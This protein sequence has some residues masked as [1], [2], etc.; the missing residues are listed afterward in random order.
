MIPHVNISFLEPQWST[1][2]QNA[3]K[4]PGPLAALLSWT[5][6]YDTKGGEKT[7][8]LW[9]TPPLPGSWVE[10]QLS[11]Y[12]CRASHVCCKTD[13]NIAARWLW[14]ISLKSEIQVTFKASLLIRFAVLWSHLF[15]K[16][17]QRQIGSSKLLFT[18]FWK[19]YT[20]A[21]KCSFQHLGQQANCLNSYG[22]SQKHWVSP[23]VIE[24]GV[25]AVSPRKGK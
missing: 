19:L 17:Q 2:P 9:A 15:L 16:G 22:I 20:R 3:A 4:P 25:W 7:F 13:E 8:S 24:Q 14:Q 5:K 11:K 6:I 21:L 23:L 12:A 1:Y 10:N 18:Q